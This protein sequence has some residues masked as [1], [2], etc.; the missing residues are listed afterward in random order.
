LVVVKNLE[1]NPEII[2]IKD[3]TSTLEGKKNIYTTAQIQWSV[4][5]KTLRKFTNQEK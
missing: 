5:E 3:P 1:K 2:F 4:S